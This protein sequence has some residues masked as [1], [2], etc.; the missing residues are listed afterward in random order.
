[1]PYVKSEGEKLRIALE[2]HPSNIVE[3]NAADHIKAAFLVS[4][5]IFS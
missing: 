5:N 2:G 4:G 1:M 3:R